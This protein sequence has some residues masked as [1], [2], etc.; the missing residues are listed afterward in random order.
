VATSG[1]PVSVRNFGESSGETFAD[2][3]SAAGSILPG[4]LGTATQTYSDYTFQANDLTYRYTGNCTLEY[5]TGLLS[6]AVSASGT[7]DAIEVTD[8]A[9]TEMIYSGPAHAVDFGSDMTGLL[10]DIDRLLGAVARLLV[11]DAG[12]T[13]AVANLHLD[14]TP[15]LPVL[16]FADSGMVAGNDDVIQ[17]NGIFTGYNSLLAAMQQSGSPVAIT[18][19]ARDSIELQNTRIASLSSQNFLF[20]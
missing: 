11:A 13:G 8:G 7:Y 4:V 18:I 6:G 20:G 5:N 15:Q 17:L 9:A 2:P 14:A 10:A 16:A 19:D 1:H 3:V 12:E